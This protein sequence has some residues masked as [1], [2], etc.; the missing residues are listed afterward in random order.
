VPLV[1]HSDELGRLAY[2][3]GNDRP[4]LS[5][6]AALPTP[7]PTSGAPCRRFEHR[8]VGS[9]PCVG[10]GLRCLDAN[11][12][13]DPPRTLENPPVLGASSETPGA[14]GTC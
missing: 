6:G 13:L 9:S 5:T 7:A 4:R 3:P 11:R 10:G 12:R 14:P 1:P 8:R 2:A